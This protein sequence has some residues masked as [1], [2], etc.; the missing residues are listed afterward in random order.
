MRLG[1]KR[2]KFEDKNYLNNRLWK[3][4]NNSSNNQINSNLLVIMVCLKDLKLNKKKGLLVFTIKIYL[5]N[6]TRK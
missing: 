1:N 6:K 4:L 3:H 5:P 2:K